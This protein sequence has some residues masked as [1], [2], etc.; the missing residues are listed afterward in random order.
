MSIITTY[1]NNFKTDSI[2]V[3]KDLLYNFNS[4]INLSMSQDGLIS[5]SKYSTIDVPNPANNV[6]FDNVI[7]SFSG[8]YITKDRD[9]IDD[10]TSY[11]HA[12]I[13]ETTNYNLDKRLYISLPVSSVDEPST[14]NTMLTES[15]LKDL[16]LYIPIDKGFYSYKTTI[17][18]KLS[19]FI[20]YKDSTLT[21]QDIGI[22]EGSSPTQIN[23]PLTISKNPAMKVSMISNTFSDNDIYI[24]CQPVDET[25]Q[26]NSIQIISKMDPFIILAQ[27]ILPYVVILV[28]FL[29][30]Y[31]LFNY[32]YNRFN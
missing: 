17:N 32:F 29:A 7:Y 21:I 13:I 14:L 10:N 16:N 5:N 30:I 9:I 24:D 15:T 2:V 8:V 25:Q 31:K 1:P 27:N 18:D 20:V 23:V 28:I 22:S 12:F 11:S 4:S 26:E 3:D 19:E 6:K